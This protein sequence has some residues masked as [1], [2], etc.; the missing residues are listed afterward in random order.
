MNTIL[1]CWPWV[2]GN[3]TKTKNDIVKIFKNSVSNNLLKS[4]KIEW[5]QKYDNCFMFK[6]YPGV[7]K[8]NLSIKNLD[9]T[10]K[11]DLYTM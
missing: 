2:S 10:F 1:E 8:K 11:N 6:G 9:K 3:I 7:Y 5:K 4:T